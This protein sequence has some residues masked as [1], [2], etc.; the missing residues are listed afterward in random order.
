MASRNFT[1]DL[2]KNKN[3]PG[4]RSEIIEEKKRGNKW[5]HVR[6]KAT[7]MPN[8]FYRNIKLRYLRTVFCKLDVKAANRRESMIKSSYGLQEVKEKD[9]DHF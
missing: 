8:L 7:L 5:I 1:V 3:D 4:R 9:I 2:R 6:Y